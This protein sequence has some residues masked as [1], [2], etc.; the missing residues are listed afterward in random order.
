MFPQRPIIAH[1]LFM[2]HRVNHAARAKEQQRLEESVREQMEHRRAIGAY[3]CC[4]EHI[5]KL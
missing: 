3:A 4:K 5:A 1:I 2:V